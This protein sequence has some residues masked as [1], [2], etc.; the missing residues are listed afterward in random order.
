MP[1][2]AHNALPTFER[3]RREGQ[4]ILSPERARDQDI[5]PM[6]VGL[7]NM[8]PDAALEATERQFIRLLG[9][10]NSIAQFHVRPF[11]LDAIERGPAARAH[12][13][14]HYTPFDELRASG[15]DALIVSGANVSQPDLS[16]EVFWEPLRE[17]VDWADRVVTSTLCSCLATHAVLLARHG[18][19]RRRLPAKRWG[20]FEHEVVAR[21][22]PLV[23]GSNTHLRVPHSRYN[24]VRREQLVEHGLHVLVE[25]A[26]AGVQVAVS[27]DGF[28][29]VYLQG[30]P[31]YDTV[32]LLKEY[33]REIVA[34]ADGRAGSYPP[35][36]DH[37][38]DH[39]SAVL[40]EE[41]RERAVAAKAAGTG[42]DGAGL[43]A[44]PEAKLLARLR[45]TWHDSGESLVGT[46]IALVYQLTHAEL[47]KPFMDGVD[48]DD[49]LGWLAGP[50]SGA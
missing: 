48:I 20:V 21:R 11:T 43:P 14:R 19:E 25:S 39:W 10:S 15:L 12:I 1:L 9:S 27:P 30:H 8:M 13:G 47:G 26:Q 36:P 34:W 33:K 31:E 44:F 45:N 50:D 4:R 6:R 49:P 46:W 32:S 40:L 41:Y 5:R 29:T 7:L 42:P 28:R 22:H 3:L 37:Y 2:V 16:R 18:I 24:E 17:V 23:A 38:L 35:L